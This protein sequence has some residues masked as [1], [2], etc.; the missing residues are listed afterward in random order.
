LAQ[1]IDHRPRLEDHLDAIVDHRLA[2]LLFDPLL[3]G[4]QP[5]RLSV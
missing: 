3:N 4:H 2:N 1:K 5:F